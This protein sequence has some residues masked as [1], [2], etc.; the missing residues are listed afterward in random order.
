M[1]T[2]HLVNR[3][4]LLFFACALMLRIL[5]FMLPSRLAWLRRV[6]LVCLVAGLLLIPYQAWLSWDGHDWVE[7]GDSA[8]R[9]G[10]GLIMV[11]AMSYTWLS[12]QSLARA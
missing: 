1:E 10:T 8:C 4:L 12:R 5:S 3:V 9:L 11:V 7:D 2:I 6:G